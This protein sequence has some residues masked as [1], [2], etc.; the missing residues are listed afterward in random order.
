MDT[1]PDTTARIS[2]KELLQGTVDGKRRRIRP[3]KIWLDPTNDWTQLTSDNFLDSNQ[4]RGSMVVSELSARLCTPTAVS[5]KEFIMMMLI[6][7]MF[8]LLAYVQMCVF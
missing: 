2:F 3:R 4:D 8:L 6:L 5:G 1:F 7:R